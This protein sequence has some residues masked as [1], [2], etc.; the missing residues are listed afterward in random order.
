[1]P[2]FFIPPTYP[3]KSPPET[4]AIMLFTKRQI[5][6]EFRLRRRRLLG[7]VE[8]AWCWATGRE[9]DPFAWIYRTLPDDPNV[10]R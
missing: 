8:R 2:I 4:E 6:R 9:Y 1:M 7:R 5:I 10:W 3:L